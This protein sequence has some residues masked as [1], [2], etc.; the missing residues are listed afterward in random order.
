MCLS[1]RDS[2]ASQE[3]GSGRDGLAALAQSDD[4]GRHAGDH[5]LLVERPP[6]QAAAKPSTICLSIAVLWF[7]HLLE[8]LWPRTRNSILGTR[9]G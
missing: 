6:G 9:R 8:R 4:L 2:A 1:D 7:G 3:A 5:L